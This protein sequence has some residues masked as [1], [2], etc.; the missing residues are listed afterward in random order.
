MCDNEGDEDLGVDGME[1]N[2]Y[3]DVQ[4]VDTV[5]DF[6]IELREEYKVSGAGC[7]FVASR[8]V[9][10][11]KSAVAWKSVTVTKKIKE[12]GYDNKELLDNVDQEETVLSEA[13]R[14]FSLMKNLDRYIANKE[15][16]IP[17]EEITL[18][19]DPAKNKADTFEYVPILK[20]LQMISQKEDVLAHILSEKEE[21][22]RIVSFK[23]G[24][25][26]KNSQF[27]KD[28]PSALQ[29]NL[30][31]DEFV[32]YCKIGNKT[33]KGKITAI[34]FTL[35]NIPRQYRSRLKDIH[36]V[37]LCNSAYVTKYLYSTILRRLVDD[38]KELE[39]S[40]IVITISEHTLTL[41]GTI[42]MVIA[43]NLGAHGI[44]GFFES[45]G[46]NV[47][48]ICRCCTGTQCEIRQFFRGACFTLR[49]ALHHLRKIHSMLLHTVLRVG[50]SSM[51]CNISIV[52]VS[53]PLISSMM[54]MR[55]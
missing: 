37:I 46:R 13:A 34:Y 18:G 22:G 9:D 1:M 32:P 29:V 44:G 2:S 6:L 10:F 21:D 4:L 38:L 43:D 47:E 15:S 50:Q 19:H 33:K 51:S 12:L 41:Y 20:T 27:F 25:I 49:T 55:D 17:P 53:L 31:V 24:S 36:L 54:L 8:L 28:H 3:A 42:T 39:I 48:K 7:S 52:L 30:Y 16:F 26:F 14:K 23:D 11:V 5:A 45:F 40:G 35:G